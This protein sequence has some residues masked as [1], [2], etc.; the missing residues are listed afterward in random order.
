MALTLVSSK[1]ADPEVLFT[2]LDR[3]GKGS[4]GE[5][6]KGIDNRSKKVVAMKIID[7]EEAEDEI[8]EIQKEITILS[9]C[10]SPFIT[11]Y[12]GSY[13]KGT[14]LWIIMEYLGGGSALDLMKAGPIDE[15]YIAT[16]LREILRGLDYLHSEGKLHRDIKAANVLL[17]ETG[18]VKLADFGVAGQL[19]ESMNKRKTFVGTPFWMAPEVITQTAYDTKADI[20]SLGIT[21]IELANGEPPHADL[22]PMRVLFLIPK[23]NPP[24]LQGNYTKPFKEFVAL[25]LNK[26]PKDR[27]NTKELLKHRFI[28]AAK[29]NSCLVDLI[30]RFRKWK[31]NGGE[32]GEEGSDEDKQPEEG[33]SETWNFNTIRETSL[34]Q[35]SH[36]QDDSREEEHEERVS[37]ERQLQDGKSA[38]SSI[39]TPITPA[40][41]PIVPESIR[42][43]VAAPSVGAVHTTG[44]VSEERDTDSIGSWSTLGLDRENGEGAEEEV[45]EEEE[46]EGEEIGNRVQPNQKQHILIDTLGTGGPISASGNKA[47]SSTSK[48]PSDA[49]HIVVHPLLERLRASIL[50]EAEAAATASIV[51]ALGDELDRPLS[52][53]SITP[54]NT[55]PIDELKRAFE[56]AEVSSPGITNVLISKITGHLQSLVTSRSAS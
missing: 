23:S 35:R 17:S 18:D 40:V 55:Q 3:I 1:D 49:L 51:S 54:V 50:T 5:V 29:K 28:K 7:L 48:N 24:D 9:Q 36:L 4:F 26:D 44:K 45:E 6:Y 8:E 22:H 19:T 14:K 39:M 33:E 41:V 47:V 43:S 32:S 37:P 10:D 42:S 53:G 16:I 2:R 20:W 52:N 21:A 11:R 25:C 31:V 38:P 27:P 12:Y 46:E 15:V 30:D 34:Q 13:L 56:L